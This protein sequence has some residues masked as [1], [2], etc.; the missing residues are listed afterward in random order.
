MNEHT[1]LLG[2]GLLADTIA[3]AH[4]CERLADPCSITAAHRL[5]IAATDAWDTTGHPAV[6][7]ACADQ[8]VP[9]LPVRAELGRVVIGPVEP[10]HS[11]GCADCADTRRRGAHLHQPGHD[12]VWRRHDATLRQRPSSWLTRL[13]A[14]LV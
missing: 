5:V 12:A 3:R 9:W 8:D 10:P 4:G 2:E 6:R 7:K 11:E 1:G 14:D 13:G